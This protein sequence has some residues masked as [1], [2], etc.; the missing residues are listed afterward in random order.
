MVKN[1]EKC[2]NTA[3]EQVYKQGKTTVME[4]QGYI[5]APG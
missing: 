3:V 4:L 1:I 5:K 2:I